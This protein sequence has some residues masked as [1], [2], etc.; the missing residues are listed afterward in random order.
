MARFLGMFFSMGKQVKE[1]ASI[2]EALKDIKQGKPIIIVDDEDREN[3]GDLMVSAE[4]ITPE[5]INFFVTH[6][7]GLVCTPVEK[8]ISD[9][10]DFHPMTSKADHGTCNFAISV[11]AKDDIETGISAL[12]R[13]I[14]IQKIVDP[15]SKASDFIRPGHVFPLNAK[16]GGVLVRCGHTEA[17]VDLSKMA[18]FKG[19]AVICEIMN[20]DGSMARVPD[21]IKF[22]KKHKLIVTTIADLVAY[23]REKEKL[24]KKLSEADLST[25][26]GKFRIHIFAETLTGKQHVALVMGD[27]KKAKN[28]LVRVHSECLTGD[29]FYSLRCDCGVQLKQAMQKIAEEGTGVLLYMGQEGRGIGLSNKISAYNLQDSGLDT[30][31]ANEKLG[32]QSD[33]RD[34]GIGA[35]ILKDF[36]LKKIRLLTNN[37]QKIVGLKGYGLEIIERVSIKTPVTNENKKYLKTKKDKM[38]HLFDD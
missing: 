30:V 16:E 10:L 17:S 35:Q 27:L 14:T 24:I 32:F 13:A 23:R 20:K 33:L 4:K 21:I 6:A 22:A 9:R 38:G 34:Y 19:A 18:G 29:V 26:F 25:Q 15:K 12:D 2:E 37:P 28:P 31:E 3:E 8:E 7:R 11:D 5:I 1:F 36:G